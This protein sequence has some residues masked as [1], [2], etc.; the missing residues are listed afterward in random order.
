MERKNTAGKE[1]GER[2]RK[3]G[4]A[5]TKGHREGR[6]GRER[7]GGRKGGGRK[8][9]NLLMI[10]L[11]LRSLNNFI[12]SSCEVEMVDE[13]AGWSTRHARLSESLAN[14]ERWGPAQ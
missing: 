7:R 14:L 13:R 9:T 8:T 2:G 1:K 5:K 6:R 3:K 11:A 10:H 4:K 12:K